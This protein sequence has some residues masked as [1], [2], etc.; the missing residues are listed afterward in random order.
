M[1]LQQSQLM[2]THTSLSIWEKLSLLNQPEKKN[3]NIHRLEMAV[4][5]SMYT[6]LA[7]N[8]GI[9]LNYLSIHN[10]LPKVC[11]HRPMILQFDLLDFETMTD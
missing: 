8:I 2:R 3:W 11:S 6:V 1:S 4:I 10:C 7:K 5:C 9:K